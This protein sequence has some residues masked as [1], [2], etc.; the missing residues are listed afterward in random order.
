MFGYLAGIVD[1]EGSLLLHKHRQYGRSTYQ[2]RPRLSVGNT[3]RGLMEEMQRRHGGTLISV[4][5]RQP[6]H[7]DMYH[8]RVFAIPEL[9]KLIPKIRP[10]LIVKARQADLLLEFLRLRLAEKGAPYGTRENQIFIKLR[11]LNSRC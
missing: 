7:K 10:H 8:W 2:F 5:R 9:V 4:G 11:S 1:G 6:H 3:H